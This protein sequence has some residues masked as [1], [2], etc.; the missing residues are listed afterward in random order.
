MQDDIPLLS[1]AIQAAF[2]LQRVFL[3]WGLFLLVS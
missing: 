2:F 1:P 3:Y